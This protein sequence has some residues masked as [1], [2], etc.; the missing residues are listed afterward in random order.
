[1]SKKVFLYFLV[2]LAS[3]STIFGKISSNNIP[4]SLPKIP[5][6]SERGEQH[7]GDYPIDV[8]YQGT[9]EVDITLGIL[10]GW[11]MFYEI[12]RDGVRIDYFL[13]DSGGEY[14]YR[15]S[16]V[17]PGTYTYQVKTYYSAD[18][19]D[20]T[21]D[22]IVAHPGQVAGFIMRNTVWKKSASP[23]F[24][25][26]SISWYP[27]L[28]GVII[29]PGCTLR[30][31]DGV[32]VNFGK[33][34]YIGLTGSWLIANGT[35]SD[36][37]IFKGSGK[38]GD[39]I[40]ISSDSAYINFNWVQLNDAGKGLLL[41]DKNTTNINNSW[42]WNDSV[43]IYSEHGNNNVTFSN[44]FIGD[45]EYGI[46]AMGNFSPQVSSSEFA[47]N[48]CGIA[49]MEDASPVVSNC[50]FC[51]NRDYG[52]INTSSKILSATNCWWGYSTGPKNTNNP[53]GEGDKAE[54]NINYSGFKENFYDITSSPP[55]NP[56]IDSI[57][58]IQT[59]EGVNLLAKKPLMMRV[60][61]SPGRS[62]PVEN[63]GVYTTFDGFTYPL[64]KDSVK[65]V[66]LYK[67]GIKKG[68]SSFNFFPDK[69][70]PSACSLNVE[71]EISYSDIQRD[72]SDDTDT[73]SAVFKDAP[74]EWRIKIRPLLVGDWWWGSSSAPPLAD[75]QQ[76]AERN[77]DFLD[78][79]YPARFK[80][81]FSGFIA[82]PLGLTRVDALAF[83]KSILVLT[84]GNACA[85][86]IVP[87]DFLGG[88][89]GI[90]NDNFLS[91]YHWTALVSYRNDFSSNIDYWGSTHEI[92]HSFG[93]ADEYD[94]VPSWPPQKPFGHMAANGW[95]V[96]Q[97]DNGC[98]YDMKPADTASASNFYSFMGNAR[99]VNH[100][101]ARNNYQY[102]CTQIGAKDKNTANRR[103][104][105]NLRIFQNDSVSAS[106]FYELGTGVVDTS[107]Q[108]DYS[109]ECLNSSDAVLSSVKFSPFMW[110]MDT[111]AGL[112]V[113]P[114]C[115]VTEYPV[116]TNKIILK[117]N[118]N[119]IFQRVITQNAPIV[120]IISPN[121]GSIQDSVCVI[122]TASDADGDKL[123]Y[124]LLCK[125][126]NDPDWSAIAFNLADT[127]YMVH[128]NFF[129]A[130][131]A[132]K[133]IA[134]DGMKT[135][136]DTTSPSQLSNRPPFVFIYTSDSLHFSYNQAVG[137]SGTVSDPEENTLPDSSIIW[138][139]SIDDTIGFGCS[140]SK[141]LS[142]GTHTI[143][144]S[145]RDSNGLVG[146]DAI[147]LFIMPD[148]LTDIYLTT[149][150]IITNKTPVINDTCFVNC[151]IK[152][153]LI[154]ANCTV[155]IYVN[156]LDS[157][158][159]LGS[160][161]V[162]VEANK[163][164]GFNARWVPQSIGYDTI[165][166]KISCASPSES[167]TTNNLVSKVFSVVSV[168]EQP[169][170]PNVTF[171]SQN[172]P[173]PAF[174]STFIKFAIPAAGKV[175]LKAYNISGKLVKTFIN[176]DY[177]PGYYT[178]RWNGDDNY[179]RKLPGGIY[180]V[181]LQNN[182]KVITRKTV[183]VK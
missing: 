4:I 175:N 67:S 179:G 176:E 72:S 137:L 101:M 164:A 110:E 130:N 92:G 39:W 116:G 24:V 146:S 165:W 38:M 13:K 34:Y 56:K 99:Q 127:S 36:M 98:V 93:L 5:V 157:M 17:S 143:S 103:L 111:T 65:Y 153:T 59:I 48:T 152:N 171:L 46:Y 40:G 64:F 69:E 23:I 81:E 132:F 107:T 158:H 108:G 91:L 169:V 105:A 19:L 43:G 114:A 32:T 85:V 100:W 180:F 28:K 75:L 77:F 133:I 82:P 102:L 147:A 183:I 154:D 76:F 47:S 156:S 115:V 55:P 62:K 150:D 42:F 37:I 22:A 83:L 15:D 9:N 52:I 33:D 74:P 78:G 160:S 73:L 1:M 25:D 7:K 63:V 6:I 30:I 94:A 88:D 177:K 68:L 149:D 113:F 168:E 10:Y 104:L 51:G 90:M 140:I 142:V 118:S 178:I 31:E 86:G 138:V 131:V 122:W 121:G 53:K 29:D 123:S 2:F 80:L 45:C 145:A 21:T 18:S 50:N 141:K 170:V 161:E 120:N 128:T 117:H 41:G 162:F 84:W 144:F 135:G 96:K 49:A 125:Q 54:G 27:V 70:V 173:N 182:G 3:S 159:L 44:G 60:F 97:R 166:V 167:D 126:N 89:V 136:E 35:Q 134:S 181:R 26:G 71:A 58:V 151:T 8:I 124:T 79:T 109:L 163:P 87:L 11:P 119:T 66:G 57:K 20:V 16:T 12:L 172:Y 112:N 95:F 106:V 155:S 129:G 14:S 139:S 61:V 174:N 148:T